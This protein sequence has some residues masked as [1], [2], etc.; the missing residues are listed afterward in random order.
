M[1]VLLFLSPTTVREGISP[2]PRAGGEPLRSYNNGSQHLLDWAPI[3]N[4]MCIIL[5]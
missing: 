5:C 4:F 1:R 2:E 3:K